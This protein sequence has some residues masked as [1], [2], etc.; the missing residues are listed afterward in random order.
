MAEGSPKGTAGIAE[1]KIGAPMRRLEDQRFLTGQGRYADDMALADMAHAYVLRSPHGHARIRSI[2]KSDALADPGVLTILTGE[3]VA[4][5][6]LGA[7]RCG[8]FPRLPPGVPSFCPT[9]PIL[10]ADKVRHVG[11]RV[12]L[13]V[14]TS[15]A[16]AKDA[17]ERISV[18]YEA[19]P[20]VTLVDALAPGAAKVWDEAPSNVSFQF[21]FGDRKSVDAQFAVA[22]H[23]TKARIHYPCAS[24]NP[25]E[26]RSALA[27][28]DPSNGRMTLYST[29]QAPFEA[30]EI[31]AAVLGIE[32][33]DL[34]VKAMDIGGAFGM[35]GQI[36]P[37]D[38]LVVWAAGK[39]KRPVKW[40]ADRGES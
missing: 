10:A 17:A 24:A 34:R 9:Q 15:L 28:R 38:V 12:A 20:A 16:A 14:A 1:S 23:V 32:A 39:L 30:R 11:D 19:L 3:D 35:K 8:S 4:K 18:Q 36:Y 25:L 6:K 13:V 7:L 27:Y 26:P 5:E 22:A 40:T 37:E 33:L 31:I 2:D 29:S 21:E